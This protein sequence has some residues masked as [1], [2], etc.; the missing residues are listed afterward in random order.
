M[1][2]PVSISD[3]DLDV[4]PHHDLICIKILQA[5]LACSIAFYMKIQRNDTASQMA[6]CSCTWRSSQSHRSSIHIEQYT[7]SRRQHER[8]LQPHCQTARRDAITRGTVGLLQ[9]HVNLALGRPPS[10]EWRRPSGRPRCKR[11]D[12]ISGQYTFTHRARNL[13]INASYC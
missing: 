2:R 4:G 13:L 3:V 5:F 11:I 7:S 10:R 6:A 9:C 12:Q 1:T 8:H